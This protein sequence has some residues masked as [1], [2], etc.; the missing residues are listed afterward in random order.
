VGIKDIIDTADFPTEN[1]TVLHA[2]RQ[3]QTDAW[4]VQALRKAGAL[5][6]GKTVTTEL[7]TYH[8]GKTRNPHNPAHT[9]GGSSSGSAAAVACGMVDAAIGTQTNGS[10]IRPGAFCG[11]AAFKPSRQTLPREGVLVQSP[12][13]DTLGL[14][15]RDVSGLITLFEAL[16]VQ[17]V[18]ASTTPE[19]S[20]LAW[21]P[22]PFWPR[23]DEAARTV[24]AQAL[25]TIRADAGHRLWDGPGPQ[26]WLPAERVVALHRLIMEA[27]IGRSFRN[28][29]ERGG[30][31]LS[32]SLQGQITRGLATSDAQRQQALDELMAVRAA[33]DA[34]WP[35]GLDAVLMPASLGGAPL[36]LDST[37]DPIFCTVATA[38]DLPAVQVPGLKLPD[39]LPLGLQ[40]LGRRGG[41]EPV[42][43]V[44][45]K[46]HRLLQP[47]AAAA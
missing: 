40:L 36:G 2:G 13:F 26:Q 17:A 45:Q 34:A 7:A 33:V 6:V 42:L 41:D 30:D 19:H 25:E 39:G 16:A 35:A 12:T 28:D 8:P 29:Y 38:L 44:A 11:V 22:T 4:I 10:V 14:F 5:V 3:P 37:G 46:L 27:D 1:G 24:W 43:R 20:C 9:P 21:W 32:A 47:G 15:A 31:Q 18:T 23:T